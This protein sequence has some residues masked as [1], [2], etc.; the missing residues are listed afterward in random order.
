[1]KAGRRCFLR[2][3]SCLRFR[4]LSDRCSQGYRRTRHVSGSSP[5]LAELFSKR[6]KIEDERLG[7]KHGSA[8]ISPSRI[9]GAE[10]RNVFGESPYP[11]LANGAVADPAI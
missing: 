1:M 10:E 6:H 4:E 3:R 9:Q 11:S 5:P 7:C 8:S 2:Y